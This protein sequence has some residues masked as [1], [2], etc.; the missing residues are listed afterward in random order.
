MTHFRTYGNGIAPLPRLG[1]QNGK[2]S[3]TRHDPAMQTAVISNQGTHERRL[4]LSCLAFM[5]FA[6]FRH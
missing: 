1:L 6:N 5:N 2:M 4:V 3:K